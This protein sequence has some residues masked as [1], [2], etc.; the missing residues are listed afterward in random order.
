MRFDQSYEVSH[1]GCWLWTKHCDQRG[2]PIFETPSRHWIAFRF[3]YLRFIGDINHH[4]L[5]L[6]RCGEVLC[7]QPEHL[8]IRGEQVGRASHEGDESH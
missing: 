8:Y 3:A 2:Y 6:H 7:V 5:V 4:R 1:T